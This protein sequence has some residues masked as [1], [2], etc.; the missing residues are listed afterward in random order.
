MKYED[1]IVQSLDALE[2][3]GVRIAIDDFGTGY[4]SL[5][6]LKKFHVHALKIDQSF[7]RGIEKS[8]DEAAIARAVITL[9]HSM[10][11]R[12]VAEGVE[13]EEQFAFLKNQECNEVQG[14]HF[15]RPM[16]NNILEE[17]LLEKQAT[18]L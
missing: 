8:S 6:Y 3:M 13:T 12:V 15:Y 17:L 4:S 5:S 10:K 14:F 11:M 1:S 2:Q 9:G 16:K 18:V 7:I